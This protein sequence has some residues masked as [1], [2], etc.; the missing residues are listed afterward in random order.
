M[1][2]SMLKILRLVPD[3]CSFESI[4]FSAAKTIP[5]FPLSPIIVPL[6]STAFI[7]Y[8]TWKTRP[9][10]ENWDAERSYWNY[11]LS[12][13]SAVIHKKYGATHACSYW[14]HFG[15]RINVGEVLKWISWRSLVQN[16]REL[17]FSICASQQR[18]WRLTDDQ[19]R[20]MVNI[21][22]QNICILKSISIPLFKM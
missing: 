9:S 12:R 22:S 15:I 3:S 18:F 8:S 5:S 17:L 11:R 21:N 10:G 4:N 20:R 1:C 7:A 6:F 19:G 13:Y 2:L 16:R 14:T